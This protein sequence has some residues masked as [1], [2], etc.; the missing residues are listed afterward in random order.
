MAW[1]R[2]IPFGYAIR[3]GE[4]I[5]NPDESELVRQIFQMYLSG[6]SYQQIAGEMEKRG[7]RYHQ[8]TEKWNKHMVKRMLENEVYLGNGMYP[9]LISNEDFLAVRLRRAEKTTE[10][11]SPSEISD[12][13]KKAV[14]GCCGSRMRRGSRTRGRVYWRCENEACGQTVSFLEDDLLKS[15]TKLL[16]KMASDPKLLTPTKTSR[17]SAPSMD[18]IRIE[19]ELNLAFNRGTGSAE[20]I[21]ALIYASAAESYAAIPD[22]TPVHTLAAL[23]EHLDAG[24]ADEAAL[25]E[26]MDKAV[27]AIR[28]D[29]K[30]ISLE[31][32]NGAIIVPDGKEEQTA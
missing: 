27:R 7:V 17:Q 25:R 16:K 12:I 24:P 20:L 14:C 8:H 28:M 21:R 3:A 30:G 23:R 22:P 5:L 10:A 9:R 1:Q 4:A 13:R 2:K 6:L 11:A 15:L 29:G 31:L 18:A 19:N 32:I 26:I